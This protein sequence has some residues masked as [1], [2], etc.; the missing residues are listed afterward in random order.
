MANKNTTKDFVWNAI[1]LT[2]NACN[3]LFFLI[4]IRFINGLDV[5]GVFTYAFALCIFL[6]TFMIYYNRSFQVSDLNDNFSFG[7]YLACRILTCIL[8]FVFIIL[9][10]IINQFSIFETG[11]ILLLAGFRTVEAI[12]DC[13]YGAIQK[14]DKLYQTGI[15]LSLKA[16][17][18]L[19]AFFVVDLLTND[20]FL[21]ILALII[22]NLF[23]FFAYDLPNYHKLYANKPK[24]TF[25][26][27]KTLLRTCLPI[28]IFS[29]LA[30]YLSN[31]Q[32][33]ILP[34]Y[35][36]DESQAIFGILI[37]PATFLSLIGSYLINPFIKTFSN[38]HK[39]QSYS[40][41]ISSTKKLLSYL[42][43]LGFFSLII[44]FLIGIPFLQIIFQLDLAQ[45][46]MSLELIILAS[47]F[48][49]TTMILSS[50]LTIL[51][52]NNKQTYIYFIAAIIAT[53]TSILF[54]PSLSINGAVLSFLISSIVLTLLYIALLQFTLHN[55][56]R[57]VKAPNNLHTFVI[58]AYQ[59]S[60]FLENCI[61]STKNQ[62][63]PSQVIIAT[64]TKNSH[65]EKLAKK[66]K[67][68][69]IEGKHT[70][71]GG[72]FDF[73]IHAANTPLVTVAHQD[74]IY[75]KEYSQEIVNAY[76]KYPK[77]TIIF[78]DYYEIRDER[79]IYTNRNLKIKRILLLVPAR[80]KNSL[81]SEAT[82]R[83]IIKFGNAICCPAVT[84]VIKNCPKK[85]FTS[86]FKCN[87]DW[88]AWET[89]SKKKGAFTFIAKSLMGHRISRESTTTSIIN[90]GIR[91]KEDYELFCRFW[92]KPIAKIL[93]K[94]Y[95]KSEKSNSLNQK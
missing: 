47:I 34:Y 55:K 63:Y 58:L 59:K 12:S 22:I 49:A 71:I 28:F 92:P 67:L 5:A 90:Q 72:D 50:L 21:A 18:G 19:L 57:E 17:F 86:H 78:T 10:S 79:Q 65:I 42:T 56:K 66:Y 53:V 91:T 16:I 48:Y 84:F 3:S 37:M 77:S 26:G 74:D 31:C 40:V 54:I 30:I 9:F 64:T 93:T 83:L 24:I 88:H 7:N 11:I 38:H 95:Q 82:K 52:E 62:S 70:N 13:Y 4:V 76:L 81:K 25:T 39:N 61:K 1:G 73:A 20:L 2:L 33:Y 41:F 35:E 8:S 43:G 75:E 45:Y 94:V 6:Y 14:Q 23:F 29:A 89:L 69:I 32:K 15:S 85:I 46:Q 51:S 44:C 60:S 27:L 68:Q 80:F 36:S 87:C